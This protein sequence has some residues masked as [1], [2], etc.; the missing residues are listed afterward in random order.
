MK[1]IFVVLTIFLLA[2]CYAHNCNNYCS[3]ENGH[4]SIHGVLMS[5]SGL[6]MLFRNIIEHEIENVLKKE[7]NSKF[8]VKINS[9]WGVSNLNGEIKSFEATTKRYENG[10]IYAT[11]VSIQTV[12]DYTKITYKDDKIYLHQI[13]PLKFSAKMTQ[14]DL[15]DTIA[16]RNFTKGLNKVLRLMNVNYSDYLGVIKNLKNSKWKIKLDKNVYANLIIEDAKYLNKEIYVEGH[17]I[18]PKGEL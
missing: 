13:T 15:S 17:V 3:N 14:K 16:S 4:K 18:I 12:C 11:D 7:T 1:K 6:N 5:S 9:W 10:G 2:S 8:K